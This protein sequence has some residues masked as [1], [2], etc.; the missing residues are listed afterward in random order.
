MGFSSFVSKR[1]NLSGLL[2]VNPPIGQALACDALECQIS[3]VHVGKAQS[4][5]GVVT[6]VKLIAIALQV[7]LT[8]MMEGADQAAL[9]DAEIAF[10]GV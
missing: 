1:S 4:R 9:E 6:E 3:A 10:N 7:L 5:A 2:A 8:D